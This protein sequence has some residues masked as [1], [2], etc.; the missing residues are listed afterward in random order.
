MYVSQCLNKFRPWLSGKESIFQC[1]RRGFDLGREDPLETE[2]TTDSCILDW[3]VLWTE[4][5]G[6]LLSTGSQKELDMTS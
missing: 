6:G 1:M 4:E 5:P 2:M 3:D